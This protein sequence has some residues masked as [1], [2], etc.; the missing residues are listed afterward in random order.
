MDF[1]KICNTYDKGSYTKES[2]GSAPCPSCPAVGRFSLHGSYRRHIIYFY[3]NGLH[4]EHM[5]IKRVQCQSC[6]ATHAV[7]P[8]DLI[9]YKLLSLLALMFI[10]NECFIAE[11]P[12][13][14]VA[15]LAGFSY[16]FIYS[17]LHTFFMHKNSIHQY[18]K[19][20]T[21]TGA[22]PGTDQKTVMG[23]IKKPYLEFQS[24]FTNHSR[25]PCFMC[26]FFGRGGGPKIG[27]YAPLSAAT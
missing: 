2:F 9:P 5:E 25:R 12:V 6:G 24:G 4:Y 11:T 13:L 10:L 7:M 17:C 26:K 16:Q 27:I 18:F 22:P 1:T 23:L 19:E 3:E 20:R 21:E 8:G 14:N 15:E